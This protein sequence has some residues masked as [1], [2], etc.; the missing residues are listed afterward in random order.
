MGG[1]QSRTDSGSIMASSSA[2]YGGFDAI[3]RARSP[4]TGASS[5]PSRHSTFAVSCGANRVAFSRATDTAPLE[6]SVPITRSNSPSLA[7]ASAIAPEP[8][9]MSIASPVRSRSRIWSTSISVSCRGMSTR[10]ST[11]SVRFRKADRSTAYANG[12]PALRRFAARLHESA[13]SRLGVSCSCSDAQNRGA[14]CI[15]ARM[16]RASRVASSMPAPAS[17]LASSRT[18]ALTVPSLAAMPCLSLIE[19]LFLR[20]DGERVHELIEIAVER[21]LELV[22]REPDAVIGDAILREVVRANLGRA[23]AGAH[24]RL[25]HARPR[26]LDL[27]QPRVE[28]ARPQHLHAFELVLQLG[29]LILLAH[30]DSR[31]DVRNAH[32]GI[33]GVD[34]LPAW[35]RRAEDIDAQILVLDLHVDFL[36]FRKHGDRG[37]GRVDASLALR[38]GH[39]LHAMHAALP[40]QPAE[41]TVALDLEDRFLQTAERT[42]G[43]RDALDAPV[44]MLGVARV[45]AIEIGSEECGL[46]AT[47]PR[48]DLDDRGTIVERVAR[49]Q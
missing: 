8:V 15:A 13:R 28:N 46:V 16:S 22:R 30:H 11:C 37:R 27:G 41:R 12:A 33:G 2:M 5:A 14:S 48:A 10:S 35:S 7:T 49:K 29:L 19:L 44:P 6:T 20:R 38:G 39:A 9:P 42:V 36:R 43:V 23:V 40:S 18:S 32:G 47:G 34:A 1:S 4:A 26:G 31:G 45:H 25:A 17:T 3:T 21:A 24:L